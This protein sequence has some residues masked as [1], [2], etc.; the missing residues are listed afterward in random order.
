M[1]QAPIFC[2]ALNFYSLLEIKQ[3]RGFENMC[4]RRFRNRILEIIC[5]IVAK[6]IYVITF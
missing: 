2:G 4:L 5:H 6:N 3:C 1:A